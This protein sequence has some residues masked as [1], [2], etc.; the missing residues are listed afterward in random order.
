M[1][2]SSPPLPR[3]MASSLAVLCLSACLDD[4]SAAESNGA[5]SGELLGFGLE[6][7][8]AVFVSSQPGARAEILLVLLTDLQDACA[9]LSD[10]LIDVDVFDSRLRVPGAK[11][12]SWHIVGGLGDQGELIGEGEVEVAIPAFE[13][14]S[15]RPAQGDG[16]V[17]FPRLVETDDHCQQ[18]Q[19]QWSPVEL[20]A[21]LQ[22]LEVD[23]SATGRVL[24]QFELSQQGDRLGG[25]FAARACPTVSDTAAPSRVQC[26]P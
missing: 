4:A 9:A 16:A 12:L 2:C 22:L 23:R 5:V 3:L 20:E 7:N 25:S 8:D 17:A 11:L 1:P 13:G 18:R 6:V 24:G 21:S 26:P 15:A 14:A 10:G 19:T